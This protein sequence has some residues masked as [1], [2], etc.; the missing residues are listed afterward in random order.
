MIW[1]LA[2]PFYH[3]LS[4]FESIKIM[5]LRNLGKSINILLYFHVYDRLQSFNPIKIKTFWPV[6]DFAVFL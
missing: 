4:A 6:I 3:E 1:H 5:T 2:G